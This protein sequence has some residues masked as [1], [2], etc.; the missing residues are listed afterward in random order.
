MT[1]ITPDCDCCDWTDIPFAPD[2]GVLASRDP[3]AID[4]AAAQ[5][6]NQAPWLSKDQFRLKKPDD[7][8]KFIAMHAVDWR[9]HV[10]A[11]EILGCGTRQFSLIPVN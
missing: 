6:I 11:A 9:P 10:A 4:Q 1:R 7:P 5:L 8:D 2:L 3:V